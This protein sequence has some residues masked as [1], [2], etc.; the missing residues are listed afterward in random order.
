MYVYH[1]VHTMTNWTNDTFLII[2]PHP[3]INVS[4]YFYYV[5]LENEVN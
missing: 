2:Y 5:L 1:I 4:L 3:E